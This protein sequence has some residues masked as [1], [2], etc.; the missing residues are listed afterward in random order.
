M[1]EMPVKRT[2][3]RVADKG[4]R[5]D[6]NVVHRYRGALL[7][8]HF[9]LNK[10]VGIARRVRVGQ[11]QLLYLGLVTC[12]QEKEDLPYARNL[13]SPGSWRRTPQSFRTVA[14]HHIAK[15]RL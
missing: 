6:P 7:T 13:A 14:L 3:R 10:G 15:R 9:I 1:P 12:P 4:N 8:E 11:F 5:C 2:N